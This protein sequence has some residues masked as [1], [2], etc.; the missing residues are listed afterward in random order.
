[1]EISDQEA[2]VRLVTYGTLSPGRKNH[3]QLSGLAGS[4]SRGMI[5]GTLFTLQRGPSAGYPGLILDPLGDRIE[6]DLFQAPDLPQHWARL[7]AFEGSAY[8]RRVVEVTVATGCVRA[9]VYV[10]HDR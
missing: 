7:D 8:R 4:W 6:V 2:A 9:F 1:M 3:G 5:T 10:A